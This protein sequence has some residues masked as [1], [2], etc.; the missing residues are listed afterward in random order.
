MIRNTVA[1][2]SIR[3]ATEADQ[4]LPAYDFTGLSSI[5]TCPTWGLVRYSMGKSMPGQGRPMALLMGAMLHEAFAAIRL[6]QLATAQQLPFTAR[7][8]AL[9][10]F[11]RET[12]EELTHT[13]T[14]PDTALNRSALC[15]IRNH[16]WEDDL[17]DKRR[18]KVNAEEAILSY[19]HQWPTDQRVWVEDPNDFRS[20][21]GIEVKFDLVISFQVD[22]NTFILLSPPEQCVERTDDGAIISFRFI[23]RIDGIHEH[24]SSA[25]L[26]AHENKSSGRLDDAWRMSY[27][28][29]HQ[30]TG[31]CAASTLLTG[32]EVMR[33][34]AIGL[35]IP[36]PKDYFGGV[37]WEPVHRE[38]YNIERWLLWLLHTV[39]LIWRW[40]DNPI[41][42]PKYSHSCNR[43]FRPC[44]FIPFC[45][46]DPDEQAQ[47]LTE[48]VDDRWSPLR[49]LN[50]KAGD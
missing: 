25:M 37:V 46:A 14:D 27:A 35:Q 41:D 8:H 36:Q 19:V 3:L 2:P 40:V 12:V 17:R 11:K 15:A 16:D 26:Y 22:E 10:L 29:S 31:Y 13:W 5:N 6:A 21:V 33:G 32:R 47:I 7:Y 43:Y 50:H 1:I 38:P 28:I 34:Y 23:G 24:G 9:R 44:A 4:H 49:E 45:Y 48:M 42:A 20:M 39:E 30:I 18:T